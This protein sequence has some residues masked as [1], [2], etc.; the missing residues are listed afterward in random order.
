MAISHVQTPQHSRNTSTI[1][2][3]THTFTSQ[4]TAGSKLICCICRNSGTAGIVTPTSGGNSWTQVTKL[5]G[6]SHEGAIYY[7]DADGTETDLVVADSASTARLWEVMFFEVAGLATGGAQASG[8]GTNSTS[9]TKATPTL[10]APGT[11]NAFYVALLAAG[12]DLDAAVGTAVG[13]WTSVA[14]TLVT[15]PGNN[16]A[17]AGYTT[18]TDGASRASTANFTDSV[19]NRTFAAQWNE[20]AGTAHTRTVGGTV[21]NGTLVTT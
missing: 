13:S 19:G 10:G 20:T 15:P 11:T 1:A 7:R 9:A 3:Y 21:I 2:S 18:I 12:A 8:T 4:A 17:F 14:L 5:T 16:R 6:T